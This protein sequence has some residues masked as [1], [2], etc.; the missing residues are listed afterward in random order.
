MAKKKQAEIESVQM[1]LSEPVQYSNGSGEMEDCFEIEICCHAKKH[2]KK[3]MFLEQ[4]M[5]RAFLELQMTYSKSSMNVGDDEEVDANE[6]DDVVKVD[7]SQVKLALATCTTD[8]EDV[9]ERF[10]ALAI[11]GII[12][13]EGKKL[14]PIQLGQMDPIDIREAFAEYISNFIMPSVMENFG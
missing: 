12:K 9:Y 14:N 2:Y 8:L 7:K 6:D 5:S 10:E 13:V 4:V 11:N 3:V 1:P